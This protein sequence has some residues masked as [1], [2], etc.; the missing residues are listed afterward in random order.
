MR[1]TL[2]ATGLTS[3]LT[4]AAHATVTNYSTDFTSADGFIEGTGINGIDGWTTAD[5]AFPTSN[6]DS[7]GQID[8]VSGQT[9]NFTRYS[10][11]AGD[12]EVGE[13]V[14]ITSSVAVGNAGGSIGFNAY[15]AFFGLGSTANNITTGVQLGGTGTD[16]LL[17]ISGD[18]NNNVVGPRDN[19]FHTIS[20][21]ITK[22]ATA[23]TFD[24]AIFF[25]GG[26][27]VESLQV[28]DTALYNAAEVFVVNQ[29]GGGGVG[30]LGGVTIDSYS[31]ASSVVPEPA[32]AALIGLGGLMIA[33]R[34]RA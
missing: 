22:T 31:I 18:V 23:D 21:E 11:V 17:S 27:A 25:D 20:A 28:V 6:V 30:A 4:I 12:F 13:T 16:F 1:K 5:G 7:N 3:F 29:N 2:F 19:E 34:R 14:T 33:R 9:G 32:S 24:V 10:R 8:I 26:A 15:G